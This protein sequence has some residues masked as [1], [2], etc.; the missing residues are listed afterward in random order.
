MAANRLAIK[1]EIWLHTTYMPGGMPRPVTWELVRLKELL[2][3]L[4]TLPSG[5]E[6]SNHPRTTTLEPAGRQSVRLGAC[7]G[8]SQTC[9]ICSSSLELLRL[10]FAPTRTSS[11]I[12]PIPHSSLSSPAFLRGHG[13]VVSHVANGQASSR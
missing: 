4:P 5:P 6:K 11:M 3:D 7:L 1:L 2:Y 8:Q 10:E 9:F 12:S 13:L